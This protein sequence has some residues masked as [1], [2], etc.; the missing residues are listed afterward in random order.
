MKRGSVDFDSNITL[1]DANLVQKY[2]LGIL[3]PSNL[4]SYL[5]DYNQDGK[6]DLTDAK[7]VLNVALGVN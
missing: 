1:T 6:V 4:Q 3:E 2:A 7:A 5:A